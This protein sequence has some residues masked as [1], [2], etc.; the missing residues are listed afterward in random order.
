MI[1]LAVLAWLK[2]ALGWVVRNWQIVLAAAVVLAVVWL[3]DDWRDRGRLLDAE[4]AA[5]A[6]AEAVA[7]QWQGIAEEQAAGI[8]LLGEQT[9]E[10]RKIL[11][12]ELAATVLIETKWREVPVEV[13]RIIHEAPDCESAVLG[14]GNALG[15]LAPA[16]GAP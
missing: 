5:R 16:G 10:Y 3:F 14:V 2:K 9:V 12:E 15:E 7:G 8:K 13:T 4:R 6:G 11:R 1:P